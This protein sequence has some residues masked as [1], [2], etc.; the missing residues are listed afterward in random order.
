MDTN[1]VSKHQYEY[2]SL[3]LPWY[4][5]GKLTAT[6]ID[7][8]EEV[9]KISVKLQR[10]L[11]LQQKLAQMVQDDPDVLNMVA[12][13]TQEQR[14]GSLLERIQAGQPP[15]RKP[16]WL[17]WQQSA[18]RV[19]AWFKKGTS[20][21]FSP[22]AGNWVKV[23]FSLFVVTQISILAFIFVYDG[24]Y[25]PS[26]SGKV[27]SQ[28]SGVVKPPLSKESELVEY[29]LAAESAFTSTDKTVLVFQFTA[30]ATDDSIQ[31]LFDEIGARVEEHPEGST[32]Y[33]VTLSDTWNEKD[34]GQLISRL[35]KNNK[36]IRLVGRGL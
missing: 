5:T 6:E 18:G 23:T 21:Y 8:V 31:Q 33:T 26:I 28:G 30:E 11:A 13:S 4:V 15:E 22:L 27:S 34:I 29:E 10:E 9:L 12:I 24:K 2:V 35:E 7:E 20:D 25:D 3:L 36:M 14:L 16:V 32:N 1:N 17:S 19:L